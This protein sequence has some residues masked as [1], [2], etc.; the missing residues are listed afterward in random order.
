MSPSARAVPGRAVRLATLRPGRTAKRPRRRFANDREKNGERFSARCHYPDVTAALSQPG[1]PL[2][3][4]AHL[5][6]I[7]GGVRAEPPT[8]QESPLQR[9][10]DTAVATV[11]A[12]SQLS[13]RERAVLRLIAMGSSY[14]EIGVALSISARTVKMHAASLRTKLGTPSKSALI[15]TLFA[16]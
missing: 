16:C 3:S 5:S 11:A 13:P 9:A 14:P 1:P 2:R 6:P 10:L 7:H 8:P 4:A 12:R 15:R